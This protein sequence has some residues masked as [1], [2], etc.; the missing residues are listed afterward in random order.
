[1]SRLLQLLV[2]LF[3]L[4]PHRRCFKKTARVRFAGKGKGKG[5][6]EGEVGEGRGLE[7]M[8]YNLN[9]KK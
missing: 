9:W 5:E 2:S 4:I 6:G 1:M 3:L 8:S 7:G